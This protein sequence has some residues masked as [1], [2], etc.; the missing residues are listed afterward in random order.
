M[1]EEHTHTQE[2]PAKQSSVWDSLVPARTF[3]IKHPAAVQHDVLSGAEKA[4][5]NWGWGWGVE[6]WEHLLCE[7]T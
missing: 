2:L 6:E 4:F 5:S 1:E 7:D 3:L